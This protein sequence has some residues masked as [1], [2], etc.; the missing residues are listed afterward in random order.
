MTGNNLIG[1]PLAE[2]QRPTTFEQW[3]G[4]DQLVNQIK[5]FIKNNFLPSMVFHGPPGSGKTTMARLISKNFSAQF[6]QLNAVDTGAKI[7]KEVGEKAKADRL[8]HSTRTVVFVDEIH[9]LTTSQQDIFLPFLESGD[10]ILIGA[11]TENPSFEL[12]KALLSRCKVLRFQVP[13]EQDLGKVFDSVT[14]SLIKSDFSDPTFRD[15]LIR[16]SKGDFRKMI[17]AIEDLGFSELPRPFQWESVNDYLMKTPLSYDKSG[18][19]HHD[20][21]SA[22]IKSIRGSDVDAALLYLSYMIRSGEDLNFIC[23]RLIVLASEDIGNAD[24]RALTM[25]VSCQQ[26]VDVVGYPEASIILGQTVCYLACAPKSN[27][28]YKAIKA[29]Q[30]FIDT[31]GTLQVPPVLKSPVSDQY[32]YPHDHPKNWVDQNYW[33]EKLPK[34]SFYQPGS[35]GFE[36]NIKDFL[37]WLKGK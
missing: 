20:F 3:V 19:S 26:A 17:S 2:A 16:W 14:S 28:S 8:L 31:V 22:L 6:V 11:T 33:P 24:P 27:S 25:A 4:Q 5:G 1:T 32:K 35:S 30:H 18:S 15:E 12:N 13:S 29:A 10:F 9:R 34:Q 7:L 23:R 36:K 37:A 21:V